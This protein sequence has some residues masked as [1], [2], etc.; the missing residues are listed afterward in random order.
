MT[1]D[2]HSFKRT[3]MIVL[4]AVFLIG[5]QRND[6]RRMLLWMLLGIA[7]IAFACLPQA[8][9]AE[10]IEPDNIAVGGAAVTLYGETDLYFTAP[11]DS[12][13]TFTVTCP[14]RIVPSLSFERFWPYSDGEE[15][16]YSIDSDDEDFEFIDYPYEIKTQ[17]YICSI[18]CEQGASYH[19]SISL[20]NAEDDEPVEAAVTLKKTNKA[21]I[22]EGG[23]LYTSDNHTSEWEEVATVTEY[24]GTGRVVMVPAKIAGMRVKTVADGVFSENAAITKLVFPEG[25]QRLGNNVAAN[26]PNLKYI[27]FPSTLDEIANKPFLGATLE[28]ITFPKGNDDYSYSSGCLIQRGKNLDGYYGS[29]RECTVPDGIYMVEGKA[30]TGTDVEVVY[31]PESVKVFRYQF[32]HLDSI[33]TA[34]SYLDISDYISHFDYDPDEYPLNIDKIYAPSGSMIEA[35]AQSLNID[36]VGEGECVDRYE[37]GEI[38]TNDLYGDMATSVYIHSD[39]CYHGKFTPKKTG[40]YCLMVENGWN[41]YFDHFDTVTDADGNEVTMRFYERNYP[42]WYISLTAGKTYYFDKDGSDDQDRWGDKDDFSNRYLEV[43]LIPRD[44]MYPED[45]ENQKL[46]QPLQIIGKTVAVK[47]A[48]LKKK[49][50]T[51]PAK[52]AYTVRNKQGAM[53]YSL[54]AAKKGSKSFKKYFKVNGKTGTITV[55]KGLKKGLYNVQIKARAAGNSQYLAGSRKATVKVRVK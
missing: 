41:G 16:S 4:S 19:V 47:Y 42:G 48:K 13:Y 50:Q 43:M 34:S 8:A 27:E 21:G 20:Y 33:H 24:S 28:S 6:I 40:D 54:V 10:T 25:C 11:E 12:G 23:F 22:A 45:Y 52:K 39:G 31:L 26:C 37:I 5:K 44:V 36:V 7:V 30:F 46:P 29:A 1:A 15:G 53:S 49:A 18:Y 55:K 3:L 9:S 38:N 17:D 35:L 32:K 2:R 14:N 51:I